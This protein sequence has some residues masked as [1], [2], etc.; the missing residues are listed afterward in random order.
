HLVQEAAV[1]PPRVY[2][3]QQVKVGAEL[4]LALRIPR[5][6]LQID[7]RL[8]RRQQRIDRELDFADELFVRSGGVERTAAEHRLAP[9]DPQADDPRVN[10]SRK[11]RERHRKRTQSPD[12]PCLP[13]LPY[14]PFYCVTV[15]VVVF[16]R[17]SWLA[18]SQLTWCTS[19]A[20]F[21]IFT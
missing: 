15:F 14:P 9:L 10:R 16:G 11:E 12:L 3:L 21:S 6:E 20:I 4:D 18:R 7:D 5:C 19:R 17:A 1:A 13:H 8:I 2:G